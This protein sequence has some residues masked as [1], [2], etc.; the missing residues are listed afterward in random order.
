MTKLKKIP[1]FKTEKEERIFWQKAD[2]TVSQMIVE[3]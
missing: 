3:Y 1:K 2:T